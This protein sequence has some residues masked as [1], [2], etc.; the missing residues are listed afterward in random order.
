MESTEDAGHPFGDVVRNHRLRRG[1][2]QE[3]LAAETGIATRSIRNIETGR[4]GHP[5]T[6]TVRL[7]AEA[8]G[9]AGV[10]REAFIATA[11]TASAGPVP[12]GVQPGVAVGEVTAPAQLPRDAPAFAGRTGCLERLWELLAQGAD[13]V[14]AIPVISGT[15]GVGKTT[16]AVHWAYQIAERFPDSL[17]Q[18]PGRQAR[19]RRAGQRPRRRPDP[20]AATRHR[21]LP[22]HRHQS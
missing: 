4:V 16:L 5:R 22:G 7:L 20:A 21:R 1:L 17:P 8:F 19:T 12:A 10:E 9:L 2:S 13:R 11:S 14:A 18:S 6:A 3:Q 15:A